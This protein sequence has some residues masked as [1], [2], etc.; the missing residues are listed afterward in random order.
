MIPVTELFDIPKCSSG[1]WVTNP[2]DQ[3]QIV[4]IKLQKAYCNLLIVH[5]FDVSLLCENLFFEKKT[6]TFTMPQYQ[7]CSKDAAQAATKD[8]LFTSADVFCAI[9]L[10]ARVDQIKEG[11]E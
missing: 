1:V 9:K 11:K 2:D 5:G 8:A 3:M 4:L 6:V 10:L 7:D